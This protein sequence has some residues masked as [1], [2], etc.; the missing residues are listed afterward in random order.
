MTAL[1]NSFFLRSTVPSITRRERRQCTIIF[2]GALH[3]QSVLRNYCC[4]IFNVF[5]MGLFRRQFECLLFSTLAWNPSQQLDPFC[6]WHWIRRNESILYRSVVD[7][8]SQSTANGKQ[9]SERDFDCGSTLA[10]TTEGNGW[11]W[12]SPNCVANGCIAWIWS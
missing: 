1:T 7:H 10:R 12:R 6:S 11:P 2:S 8:T 4:C 9:Q 3:L 5:Q